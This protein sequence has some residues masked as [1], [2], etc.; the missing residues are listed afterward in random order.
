[1]KHFLSAEYLNNMGILVL[2]Y[3]LAIVFLWFGFS[4]LHNPFQWTTFLPDW[5]SLLPIS[6]TNF[7]MFN[8]LFEVVGAFL[9]LVGAYTRIVALLLGLHLLA[10]ATSI[11]ITSTGVRDFGLAIAS[12]ALAGVGAGL[13]S[14]DAL[15]YKE[16]LVETF[17]Q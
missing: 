17:S 7:V 2:R 15:S 12:L 3:G 10:I 5:V 11:G 13:F 6:Q 16:E 9:L 4:Q 8:G 1:M 14:I